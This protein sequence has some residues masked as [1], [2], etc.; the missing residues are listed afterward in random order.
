MEKDE[1]YQAYAND[2]IR[3]VPGE[4]LKHLINLF[5]FEAAINMGSE[6]DE[7]TLERTIYYIQKDYGYIPVSYVASAFIQGSLGRLPYV[8]GMTKLVP[9]TVHYWLGELSLEYNRAMAKEKQKARESDVAIAYDLHK[10]PSGKA[11]NTKIDWHK[12]KLITIDEWDNIS[13]KELAGMIGH[14]HQP[15]PADFGIKSKK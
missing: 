2:F 3:N 14:G 7:K 12:K 15:I 5:M 1:K 8:V 4:V 6:V 10:Y 11:I 13:L 9:K